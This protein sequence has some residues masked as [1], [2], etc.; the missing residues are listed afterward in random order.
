MQQ[1]MI[2]EMSTSHRLLFSRTPA[3]RC[4]TVKKSS[5]IAGVTIVREYLGTLVVQQF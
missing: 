3:W 4:R 2:L 5:A 1:E